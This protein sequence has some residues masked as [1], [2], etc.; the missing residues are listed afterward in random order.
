LPKF[1]FPEPAASRECRYIDWSGSGP[2]PLAVI[3]MSKSPAARRASSAE[4]AST[5][6]FSSIPASLAWPAMARAAAS[7]AGASE[8][9]SPG[10]VRPAPRQP[11]EPEHESL[12]HVGGRQQW[13]VDNDHVDEID[14]GPYPVVPRVAGVCERPAL[15]LSPVEE[16]AAGHGRL[17]AEDTA[18]HLF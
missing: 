15:G 5:V 12:A 14:R 18:A 6:G 1:S 11:R 13:V 3:A 9:K 7:R 17:R 16:R 2:W 10:F 8:G 4:G